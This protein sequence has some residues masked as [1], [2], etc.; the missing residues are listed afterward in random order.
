MPRGFHGFPWRFAV[1]FIAACWLFG[2]LYAF[3][4]PLHRRLM[5][6]RG[7][8]SA[9]K[10][11][12]HVAEVYGRPITRLELQ[13]AM[14]EHLW[15]RNET[16][17]ALGTEAKKQTRW[18]ALENLVNDRILHA[19]RVM[20]GLDHVPPI[21][22]ARHE[23]EFQRRQLADPEDFAKRLAGQQ[24][25]QKSLDETIR[26][27]QLDEA[28]IQEKIAHRLA[29]V[30]EAEAQAW[31][32]EFK[33]TLEVP[34]ACHAAHIFLTRHD[35]TKP[36]REGEMQEIHRKL[37][38]KEKTFAALAAQHS[39][40]ERT[41]GLGGDLGWLTRERTPED[42]MQA[43]EKLKVGEFSEPVLTRL[44]WHLFALLERQESR[45]PAFAEVREE[46][47]AM[48]TSKRRE[49]AVKSLIAELRDRSQRPTQFVFYHPE[50]IDLAEPAP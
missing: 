20:N 23:S 26:D 5:A 35:P 36:D 37:M 43:L 39:D 19:F 10:G 29:E 50:I 34:M 7:S 31:Y 17:A 40:D 28:W 9:G 47:L 13:E 14:R 16:W 12:G 1:Y 4:G 22:A 44:G 27:A 49:E 25:T 32:D 33:E 38:A 8:S 3:K 11:G 46:I 15:K 41:K 2:D 6:G 48:L 30:T 42:L 24:E 45:V 21:S 18:L